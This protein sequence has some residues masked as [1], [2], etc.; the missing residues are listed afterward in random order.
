MKLRALSACSV[1][2]FTIAGCSTFKTPNMTHNPPCDRILAEFNPFLSAP[3]VAI[4][5]R[6]IGLEVIGNDPGRSEYLLRV[7]NPVTPVW[8]V[9]SEMKTRFGAY[10]FN[11][12]SACAG[13]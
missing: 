13:P 2:L 10:V 4:I 5:S 9:I 7:T 11:A 12:R 6:M 8:Q 1:L 3:E